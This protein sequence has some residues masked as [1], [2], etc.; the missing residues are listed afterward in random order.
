MLLALA[1]VEQVHLIKPA[2][3]LSIA[4]RIQVLLHLWSAET[5]D[6]CACTPAK[7]TYSC[8]ETADSFCQ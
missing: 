6:Y 8:A 7:P 5:K 2:A 4:L 1:G 3:L